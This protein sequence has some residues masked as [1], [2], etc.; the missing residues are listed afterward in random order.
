MS[1]CK[2]FL[3]RIQFYCKMV[4]FEGV[5]SVNFKNNILSIGTGQ[6]TILFYDLRKLKFLN[7]ENNEQLQLQT[8]GGWIV[9]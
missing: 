7:K 5:R 3:L 2:S 6:G 1:V 4:S 8:K 9:R